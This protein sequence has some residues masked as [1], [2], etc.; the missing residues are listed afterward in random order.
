MRIHPG[1]LLVAVLVLLAWLAPQL[2]KRSQL[3]RELMVQAEASAEN[4]PGALLENRNQQGRLSVF[5]AGVTVS[6][7]ELNDMVR[8]QVPVSHRAR[9]LYWSLGGVDSSAVSGYALDK[10]H[11]YAS[12]FLVGFQPFAVDAPWKPL[13]TLASRKQYQ[14]DELQYQQDDVWQNSAQAWLYTRGDC[15]DHALV[16]ADWLTEMGLDARVALG[17]YKNQGHAWVVVFEGEKTYLLEATDKRRKQR[18][19]AFPLASLAVDYRA[20]FMFNR[21]DFWVKR[22]GSGTNY[23]EGWQH[24]SRFVRGV[25]SASGGVTENESDSS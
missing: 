21:S 7:V 12:S 14:L 13:Y 23:R 3:D 19:S 24:V 18:W 2:P 16:L 20:D 5:E 6:D 4:I 9:T 15:E 10:R 25:D 8:R 22:S 1:V 11:Y 17:Y